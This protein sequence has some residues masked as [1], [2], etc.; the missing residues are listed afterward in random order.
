MPVSRVC[1]MAQAWRLGRGSSMSTMR[2]GVRAKPTNSLLDSSG[3]DHGSGFTPYNSPFTFPPHDDGD[4]RRLGAV[5]LET[6]PDAASQ[7][8]GQTLPARRRRSDAPVLLGNIG[9]EALGQ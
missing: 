7:R 3:A 9:G 2:M 8:V 1:T 4:R 5:R 6:L